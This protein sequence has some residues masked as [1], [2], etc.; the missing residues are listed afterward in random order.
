MGVQGLAIPVRELC[1][2]ES[3][4]LCEQGVIYSRLRP[5]FAV[6]IDIT[7]YPVY[8]EVTVYRWT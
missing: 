6:H 8:S 2:V 5:Y 4:G 7:V 3:I 1:Q